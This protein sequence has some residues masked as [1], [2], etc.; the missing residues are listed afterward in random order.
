MQ[1]IGAPSEISLAPA[2]SGAASF[3]HA[4]APV[5]PGDPADW[6]HQAPIASS[7]AVLVNSNGIG[8][9]VTAALGTMQQTN[10]AM[11]PAGALSPAG[12][13]S[14]TGQNG[15]TPG[16]GLNGI[17]P[18]RPDSLVFAPGFGPLPFMEGM[19]SAYQH[20]R[21]DMVVLD[22]LQAERAAPAEYYVDDL[23]G[24][25]NSTNNAVV[26]V[27]PGMERKM[28][29]YN[30]PNGIEGRYL[31]FN[32]ALA[33]APCATTSICCHP[34]AILLLLAYRAHAGLCSRC[35]V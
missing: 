30:L 27:V 11:S 28:K 3:T 10:G 1:E 35:F 24:N 2:A 34:L 7:A 29:W 16:T 22:G 33:V 13:M 4:L 6:S 23:D 12:A 21:P 25:P 20:A 14:P 26:S 5:A 15:L 32:S 17:K 31:F 18:L 9:T 19:P 8:P